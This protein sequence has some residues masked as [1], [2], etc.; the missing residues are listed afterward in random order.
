MPI[1]EQ[2]QWT[3]TMCCLRNSCL[4]IERHV[5]GTAQVSERFEGIQLRLG[6]KELKDLKKASS[7]VRDEI[8][9][10]SVQG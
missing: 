1:T 3:G 7:C 9:R 8:G 10:V 6:F 5:A 4:H 2:H